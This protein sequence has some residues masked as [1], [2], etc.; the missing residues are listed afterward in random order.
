M[1]KTSNVGLKTNDSI[2]HEKKHEITY[3]NHKES[4]N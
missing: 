2:T 3:N 1:I 4:H